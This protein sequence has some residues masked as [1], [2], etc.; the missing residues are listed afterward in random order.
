MPRTRSPRALTA[1]QL[2]DLLDHLEQELDG[3]ECDGTMR[4]AE[5]F[6]RN[7]GLNVPLTLEWLRD[8][9]AWCDCEVW[10]NVR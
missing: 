10:M 3:R 1:G 7:R 8:E 6:L 4:L 2:E 5:A 9:G